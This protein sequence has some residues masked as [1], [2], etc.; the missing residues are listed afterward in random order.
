VIDFDELLSIDL[1]VRGSSFSDSTLVTLQ[2]WLDL[3]YR[4]GRKTTKWRSASFGDNYQTVR[5]FIE[6][7]GAHKAMRGYR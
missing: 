6:A 5:S 4:D 7:F 1:R 3:H 2:V